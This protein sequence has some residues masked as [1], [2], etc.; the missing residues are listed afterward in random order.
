MRAVDGRWGC[1]GEVDKTWLSCRANLKRNCE[2]RTFPLETAKNLV[3]KEE[4]S[5][6]LLIS[7]SIDTLTLFTQYTAHTNTAYLVSPKKI[8]DIFD[9]PRRAPHQLTL[10][11]N[12]TSPSKRLES[13]AQLSSERSYSRIRILSA[14]RRL[15]GLDSDIHLSEK[16]CNKQFNV[17]SSQGTGSDRGW[18]VYDDWMP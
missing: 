14:V 13:T 12:A 4:S 3:L 6:R 16:H 10:F 11:L 18:G 8:N 17:P 5:H 1:G 15:P 9:I 7:P 2:I